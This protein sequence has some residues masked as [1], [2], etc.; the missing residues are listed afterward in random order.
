MI[1]AS[2]IS[3]GRMIDMRRNAV[4]FVEGDLL[5]APP[6]G[7]VDGAPHGVGHLIG[8][9]DGA[10]FNVARSAADGLDQRA[11]RAEEAFL[12]GVED[13]PGRLRA[14]RDLREVG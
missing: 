7:L 8:V 5:L 10:A 13:A 3:S 1:P 12:I 9:Q 6:V 14:G 2:P 4:F 11:L